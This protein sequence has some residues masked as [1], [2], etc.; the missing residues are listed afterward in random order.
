MQNTLMGSYPT[1]PCSDLRTVSVQP[2]GGRE[3]SEWFMVWEQLK[4]L[5]HVGTET[6]NRKLKCLRK[7]EKVL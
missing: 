2:A 3:I 4:D 5:G 1:G 7:T 6:Y